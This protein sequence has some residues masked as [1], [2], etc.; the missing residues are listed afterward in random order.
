MLGGSKPLTE[1]E[2]ALVR[3]FVES[4]LASFDTTTRAKVDVRSFTAGVVAGLGTSLTAIKY[5]EQRRDELA[6]RRAQDGPTS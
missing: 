1:K 4:E 6:R 5:H 2:M 3:R